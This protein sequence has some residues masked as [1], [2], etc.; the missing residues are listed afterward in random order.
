MAQL[1]SDLK[2][3]AHRINRKLSSTI[4][5]ARHFR[6]LGP[7]RP[8]FGDGEF[9]RIYHVH[10]RK[11]AGTSVNQMFL[12]LSQPDDVNAL[13]AALARPPYNVGSGEW[14]FSAWTAT[15]LKHPQ[16]HYGFS[17]VPLWQ[18]DLPP[19]TFRF[20]VLRDPVAR[21]RSLYDMLAGYR[22]TQSRH[23]DHQ[24]QIEW[25]KDGFAGFLERAPK[26]ELLGQLS[27]FSKKLDP[28]EGLDA[29]GELEMIVALEKLEPALK[30]MGSRFGLPLYAQHTRAATQRY[31][32][33]PE[34]LRRLRGLLAPEQW[35]YERALMLHEGQPDDRESEFAQTA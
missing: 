22:D 5:G 12:A 29:V 34:E 16:F 2:R 21:V 25:V 10:S 15:A 8:I 17:H 7:F 20:T 35:F 26:A 14:R 11:T 28:Q 27:M 24:P 19:R 18:L 6:G 23:P 1:F 4:G 32:P 13:Y 31:T 3:T 9:E 30:Q 33:T